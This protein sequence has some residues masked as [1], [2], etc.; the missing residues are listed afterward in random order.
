MISDEFITLL[1]G[2]LIHSE[3][4][5]MVKIIEPISHRELLKRLG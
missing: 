1:L 2:L 5:S 3:T 4:F